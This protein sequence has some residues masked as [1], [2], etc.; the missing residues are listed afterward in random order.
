MYSAN[1]SQ[2]ARLGQPSTPGQ[3]VPVWNASSGPCP[4]HLP[5]F[6]SSFRD[7]PH[8]FSPP[9]VEGLGPL[10]CRAAESPLRATFSSASQP[11]PIIISVGPL[12]PFL[13]PRPPGGHLSFSPRRLSVLGG[14]AMWSIFLYSHTI[15][16]CS[17]PE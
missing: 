4:L 17:I 13:W 10:S 12:H 6:C 2:K 14:T 15:Q 9:Q 7:W 3:G 5:K 11:H 1:K 8:P 16:G